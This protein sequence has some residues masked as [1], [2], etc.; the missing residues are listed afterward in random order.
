MRLQF[1]LDVKPGPAKL[2][3]TYNDVEILSRT[4]EP[5]DHD[6]SFETPKQT[7]VAKAL[8]TFDGTNEV[9]LAQA[10]YWYPDGAGAKQLLEQGHQ[11]HRADKNRQALATYR[12]AVRILEKV[13]P[14]SEELADAYRSVGFAHLFIRCRKANRARHR[15]LG[16][17]WYEKAIAV[18]ERNGNTT[19]LA[20]N[21][22]NIASAYYRFGDLETALA[23]NVRG[24]EL[25]RARGK[26]NW[27]AESAHAWAHVAGTYLAMGRLD[28]A[29]ATIDEGLALFGTET[30]SASYFY[31]YRAEVLRAR[32]T[33][34]DAKAQ[35][36]AP[37][38]ACRIA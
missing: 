33:L 6:I 38:N 22:T 1:A 17:E 30:E 16:L 12:E 25:E 15:K 35:E 18:W 27:D 28:E 32:A 31:S 19:A 20:G 10:R 14:D 2:R 26:E 37:P 29:D 23:C 4:L 7:G 21:L 24:M 5:G 3:V 11:L 34:F 36:L 9:S 8:I 13:A